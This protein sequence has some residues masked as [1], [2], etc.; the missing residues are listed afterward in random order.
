MS[1]ELYRLI[2][3]RLKRYVMRPLLFKEKKL[4]MVQANRFRKLR[5]LMV[6]LYPILLKEK[7]FLKEKQ[8]EDAHSFYSYKCP[9]CWFELNGLPFVPIV[10]L[11]IDHFLDCKD[12][13][14]FHDVQQ[15]F[16][17]ER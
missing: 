15:L 2:L 8:P 4:S 11:V 7:L 16:L 9:D 12:H 10:Y 6:C 5:K 14:V 1:P 3:F 17:G 13:R